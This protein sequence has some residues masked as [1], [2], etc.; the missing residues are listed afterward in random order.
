MT[1]KLPTIDELR[2]IVTTSLDDAA[3][4]ALIGDVSLMVAA[5]VEALEGDRQAAII[6]YATADLIAGT[7]QNSG[8][9]ALVSQS[10]GD[11]SETYAQQST[12]NQFGGTAY[13]RS[14]VLL[15]PNGCLQKLGRRRATFEK[16]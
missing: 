14:A 16:V 2:A 1:I 11:A 12:S 10:L 9:G 4:E 3:L 15:D 7:V 5:C 13:W 6:K 8:A